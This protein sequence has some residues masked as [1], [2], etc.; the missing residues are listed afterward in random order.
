MSS[1]LDYL[2]TQGLNPHLN[3]GRLYV[4]PATK[5]TDDIRQW[6]KAHKVELLAELQHKAGPMQNRTGLPPH[7]LL[8]RVSNLLGCSGD[9]LLKQGF[10]EPC[11][12]EEQAATDPWVLAEGI[13]RNPRWCP[14]PMSEQRTMPP[15]PVGQGEPHAH[16]THWTAQIAPAE[17][18]QARDAYLNHLLACPNCWAPIKRYCP[19]GQAL[20]QYYQNQPKEA[21]HD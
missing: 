11:D 20:H 6:V 9:Y 19:E 15:E 2:R 1:A 8:V 12:L 10:L 7:T 5:L 4:T 3:E 13:R 18:L 14:P 17:W 21:R 16:T